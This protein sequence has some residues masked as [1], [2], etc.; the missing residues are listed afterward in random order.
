MKF[1]RGA[2]YR[3]YLK[4]ENR[5]YFV[6]HIESIIKHNSHEFIVINTGSPWFENGHT[7]YFSVNDDQIITELNNCQALV[8]SL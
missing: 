4:R 3:F 5:T 1:K 6:K 2:T 8:W 7:I